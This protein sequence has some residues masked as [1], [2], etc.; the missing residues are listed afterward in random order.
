MFVI[1]VESQSL[2]FGDI[3]IDIADG[4]YKIGLNYL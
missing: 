1:P 2:N 4:S 3:E